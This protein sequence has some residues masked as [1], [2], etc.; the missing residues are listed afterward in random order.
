MDTVAW[1]GFGLKIDS[2]V[3]KDH[4]FVI[5]AKK[6]FK[7]AESI[8]RNLAVCKCVTLVS[9]Y[10]S[11]INTS[12]SFAIPNDAT[13]SLVTPFHVSLYC[14]RTIHLLLLWSSNPSFHTKHPLSSPLLLI[15]VYSHQSFLKWIGCKF[16]RLIMTSWSSVYYGCFRILRASL[17]ARRFL[18]RAMRALS[19]RLPRCA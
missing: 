15:L 2:Q 13:C 1:C 17:L 18:L 5:N 14:Y 3:T 6:A 10:L 11:F 4:E 16:K 7:S 8:L 19:V 9:L 12:D